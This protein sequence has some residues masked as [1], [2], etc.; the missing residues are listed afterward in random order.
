MF[1]TRKSRQLL[2]NTI[3]EGTLYIGV[4]VCIGLALDSP[5]WGFMGVLMASMVSRLIKVFAEWAN[6]GEEDSHSKVPKNISFTKNGTPYIN[7][8]DKNGN[9]TSK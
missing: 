3:F 1:K 7:T 5:I 4:G 9:S 2:L 6:D 8:F